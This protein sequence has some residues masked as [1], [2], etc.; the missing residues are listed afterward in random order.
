MQENATELCPAAGIPSVMW[1]VSK[2]D[3]CDVNDSTSCSCTQI[4]SSRT[5]AMA[6]QAV[7]QKK[8]HFNRANKFLW[9]LN[10]KVWLDVLL[11]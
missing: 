4:G 5:T 2:G 10:I 6:V 11:F 1:S 3:V 7:A 8:Q 9:S